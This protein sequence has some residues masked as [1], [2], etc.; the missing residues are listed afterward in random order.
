MRQLS[1]RGALAAGVGALGAAALTGYGP[2]QATALAIPGG[3]PTAGGYLAPET[4][5]SVEITVDPGV[6]RQMIEAY[7]DDE[8][9]KWVEAT[10]IVDG[11]TYERVGVR[12]KGNV[13]LRGIT[14]NTKP[15]KISWLVRFDKYVDGAS[16]NGMSSMVIRSSTSYS[17]LNEAVA[18][19]L[20]AR[21]GLPSEKAAY[22]SL[23]VNGSEPALRLT[24]QNPD[25]TWVRQ[26]FDVAGLLYKAKAGGD[27][28]YRGTD[29]A[30]Y[31]SFFEQETGKADLSPLIEFL[32]FINESSDA[33][34]QSELA[35][36]VEVGKLVTYLAF[37]DVIDNL[38]DVS[39]T[40]G[41]NNTFL[42]WA[43]QA[44]QMTVVA[45]D[46]NCA[47][48]L[49]AGFGPEP[50]ESGGEEFVLGQQAKGAEDGSQSQDDADE[51]RT[52]PLIKRFNALLDGE[53]KVAAERDRLKQALYASGEAQSI[54]DARAKLLT[55]QAAALIDPST[56]ATEKQHI[57]AYFSQ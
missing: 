10:V 54:L 48:G 4:L 21:T 57:A 42:W 24:C 15:Q 23:R 47:F 11:I 8:S 36:R 5:H 19:E 40:G 3:G 16:H 7:I 53:S 25:E 44:R 18:L 38:D 46:H 31:K 30:V 20:L 49:Q 56:V 14:L 26:N 37:E 41:G 50:P 22:I 55:D 34:F 45:W 28:A 43:E 33:A 51:D 52:N 27:Y 2:F 17:A 13:S 39:L 6:Y 35:Q 29:P 1:R 32:W 12:L 9:K